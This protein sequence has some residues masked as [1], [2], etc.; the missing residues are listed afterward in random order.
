MKAHFACDLHTHTTNSDGHDSAKELIEKAAQAGLKVLA[1]TDHD[2]IPQESFLMD[3]KKVKYRNYAEHIGVLLIPGI[4]ISCDT[5]NEDV[6]LICLGCDWSHPYLKALEERVRQ[7]KVKSY[8]R[9]VENLA[10]KGY[11]IGWQEVLMLTGNEETPDR[12]Q[13]K[14]IFELMAAKGIVK[15]WSEGK[16]QVQNDPELA[17]KREKPDP[18]EVIHFIHEAGGIVIMAH[19]Y[20]VREPVVGIDMVH[21][22]KEYIHRL[23]DKGLD[24]I[25][26][27]YTYDK[28]SYGGTMSKDEIAAE[29]LAEFGQRAAVLSGGSDCHG[30]TESGGRAPRML[31]EEGITM[32]YF[33]GNPMLKRFWEKT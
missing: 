29:V 2:V 31:G 25:E 23:F 12:L 28:T 15:D 27:R 33:N 4:E 9:L 6:H 18:V 32:E 26:V 24:G 21:T 19:P 5:E 8:Q 16:K 17:V 14:Q 30:E 3:G 22:R 11:D 1:I 13:K 10:A 7:S 20:L